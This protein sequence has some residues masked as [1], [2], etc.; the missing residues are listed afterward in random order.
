MNFEI[1]KKES[2]GL[3]VVLLVKDIKELNEL[4]GCD[5]A[6]VA[7]KLLNSILFADRSYYS[8]G[9][10]SI[11]LLRDAYVVMLGEPCMGGKGAETEYCL[12]KIEEL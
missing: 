12:V 5:R 4:F 7:Q 9:F 10:E 1:I 3:L 8:L 2:K 6:I 11:T